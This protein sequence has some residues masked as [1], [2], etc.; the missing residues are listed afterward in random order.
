MR[1]PRILAAALAVL[2]TV[3]CAGPPTAGGGHPRPEPGR[4]ELRGHH[5][6]RPAGAGS[7]PGGPPRPAVVL[8]ALVRDLRRPGRLGRRPGG[9][10]RSTGSRVLGVPGMEDKASVRGFVAEFEL[11]AIPQL[12]D[13]GGALWRRFEVTEQS[14]YVLLDREGRMVH[15]GWLDDLALTD[16]ESP[17]GRLMEAALPLAVTAG[18]LGAVNPC[19]FAMLPAYLSMLVAGETGRRGGR[20]RVALH[21]RADRRLPGGVRG[22][23]VVVAPAAGWLQPRLPWLTVGLRAAAG[24]RRRL[25]VTGGQLPRLPAPARAPALTGS[26]TSMALFGAAYALASPSCAAARS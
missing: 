6:G 24:G 19:G 10:V 22:L 16:R 23:R 13:T 3:G 5:T 18:M 25:A 15:R 20:P 26:V 8:G 2:V 12:D 7:R 17:D 9:R 14:T 21:R 11:E 1:V 4:V